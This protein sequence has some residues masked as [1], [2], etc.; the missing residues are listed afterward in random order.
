MGDAIRVAVLGTGQMGAGIARLILHKPP[1]Q[2]VGACARR[3]EREGLDLGLAVGLDRKLGIAVKTDLAALIEQTQPDIAIQATC[4][5]LEDAWQELGILLEHGVDVISIAEEMAYPAATSAAKAEQLGKMAVKHGA[6]VLG[7][8]VNPGFVLD[9][10]IIALTGACAEVE[11]ITATRINDLSPYGPTVLAEQGIGLTPEMFEHGLRNGSVVGHVGFEQ[12]LHM[13]AA[14]LGWELE[15]IEQ[16][17][18]PI[19]AKVRR[20]TPL[21]TVEPGLVAGCLHT[22]TAYRDGRAV[23]RL[24]HPQQIQPHLEGIE[25]GDSIEI[26]GSPAINLSGRP[27]IPG[28]QATQALA[29]NMIPQVVQ[30]PPGL[31]C[32]ADLPVP[33]AMLGDAHFRRFRRT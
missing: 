13:I 19:I 28:G 9:L 15:R 3:T 33:A 25:T 14:A 11:T 27:E 23:I 26:N 12:S 20:Q 21:V 18:E 31:Y 2:L 22:A 17:R 8:G 16:T 1:L 5:T 30:A 7:T 4:S 10:L 24:I 6:S 29:V 32:M